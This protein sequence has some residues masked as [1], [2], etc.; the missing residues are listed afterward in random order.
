MNDMSI[1]MML[2]ILVLL[3]LISA[4]FSSSETAMM[5]INRYRLR[6]RA[7]EGDKGA[8]RILDL[9]QRPDRLLGVILIGNTFANIVASAV[10]TIIS[11]RL[12]A[13][14][15]VAI[16]TFALTL[17]ILIF[18]EVTPKTLA[19][20]YPERLA[21]PF[22]LP[23]LWLLRLLHPLVWVTNAISNAVL[24]IFRI[25]IKGKSIE[26]LTHEE[27]R[28]L[29][30]EAA[31]KT[32][33][34]YRNMLLGIL[35]LGAVTVE[36]IMITRSDMI[37]VDLEHEMSEIIEQLSS[38]DHTRLPLY[39]GSIENLLGI[40]HLRK[41]LPHLSQENL[42]KTKL[43]KLSDKPYYIP[44]ATPLN[45][46]L[47]K[48][49]AKKER[50]GIVVDEYGDIQGL[51]TLDDILEEIVGEFTTDLSK[52]VE[53]IVPRKDGSFDIDG[54]VN[55]RDL[56][57]EMK[58]TLPIEGPKTVSGLIVEYLEMIPDVS[59]CVRIAGYPIEIIDI[60]DKTIKTV[61]V[62]PELKI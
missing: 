62:W 43:R 58:W 57:R 13:N 61:R 12:Y 48:M 31:G 6:H 29:I 32:S 33:I 8:K 17:I 49:R 46:L 28:T 52:P 22:S 59:L 10:A 55:L 39:Q 5:S 14:L 20:L 11:F 38:S 53:E 4:F 45:N 16:G 47:T 7:N 42:S 18:A 56:N 54:S 60:E 2:I 37:G 1:G 24:G 35:D 44:E 23:L 21:Y 15:G 50:M 9:L 27:L 36:D 34:E 41:V 30:N 26:M 19:A 25:K 3:V 51:A 40:L